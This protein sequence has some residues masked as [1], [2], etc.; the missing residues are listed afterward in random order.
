MKKIYLEIWKLAKPYYK[1]AKEMGLDP[2]KQET[3]KKLDPEEMA[4]RTLSPLFPDS[5]ILKKIGLLDN[6][7]Y[8]H[9]NIN[10][11]CIECHGSFIIAEPD[12]K[13]K[14]CG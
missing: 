6:P 4:K 2:L 10:L 12:G 11:G 1:K 3:A 13:L 7:E 9:N 5:G 14:G 8:N